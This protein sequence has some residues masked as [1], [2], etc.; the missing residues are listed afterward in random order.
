MN[1]SKLRKLDYILFYIIIT[2]LYIVQL[3]ELSLT[4]IIGILIVA[5]IPTLILGTISN[6]IFK[7]KY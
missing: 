6:F 7:K 5:I 4:H 3:I 2:F 1:F